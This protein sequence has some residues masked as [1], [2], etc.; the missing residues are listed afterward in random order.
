MQK[1]MRAEE[2]SERQKIPIGIESFEKLRQNHYYFVDKTGFIS[3]LIAKRTDVLLLTRPRRFGKTLTLSM[4]DCFFSCEQAEEH[5]KLFD[6]LFVSQ[7]AEA[8]REQGKYPCVFFTMKDMKT[9]SWERMQEKIRI[10][11]SNLYQRYFHDASDFTNLT[12]IDRNYIETM[13]AQQASLMNEEDALWKLCFFLQKKYGHKVVLLIDEYDVP[14]QQSFLYHFYEPCMNFM[15]NFLSGALKT[16]SYMEFSV[17]TGVLRIAKE[18]IFS[19]LNNLLVS[20]VSEET[21]PI[22]MGFT[23]DEVRQMA[24]DYHCLD[25]TGEIQ[26]WYDGYRFA[27]IEIYNP[28]SVLNYF[29]HDCRPQSYWVNTSTNSLLNEWI[30]RAN[31]KQKQ[32]LQRLL[33][34]KSVTATIDEGLVYS[35]IF[36]DDNVLYTLM[37]VAGYLTPRSMEHSVFGLDAELVIPNYE[38]QSIYSSEILRKMNPGTTGRQILRD[39]LSALLH[40]DGSAFQDKL[41]QLILQFVSVYD[42]ANRESFYHGF[43]L[44]MTALLVPE[45]QVES[46]RESGYGRFDLAIYPKKKQDYGVLLEFKVTDNPKMLTKKAEEAY[47]QIQSKS[48]VS[49]FLGKGISES[50]VWKYGVA[51]CGKRVVIFDG[52]AEV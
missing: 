21:Y 15:R 25:K 46:N 5:R 3:E 23:V 45:Y 17:M 33:T 29:Y 20:S 52:R 6:G 39:F 47:Q 16:N 41:Q 1:E 38:V 48:Y 30:G 28:W 14:I 40:G 2:M 19:G 35:D 22:V 7:D 44:G 26:K 49:A 8:M 43:L 10:L 11:L 34:G 51:F 9:D 37:L 24:E 32:D 12:E 36:K 13:I 27:G 4:L 42:A 50:Q 18:S 31:D